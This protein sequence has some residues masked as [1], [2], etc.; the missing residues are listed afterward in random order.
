MGLFKKLAAMGDD[1][2]DRK[3]ADVVDYVIA[4][5]GNDELAKKRTTKPAL[6]TT[7][8]KGGK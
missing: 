6:N 1:K 5:R 3:I 4:Q 2:S 7:D 8:P